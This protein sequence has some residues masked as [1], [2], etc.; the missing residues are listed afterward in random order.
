MTKWK[1]IGWDDAAG[2]PQVVVFP[3]TLQHSAMV[4]R[5]VVPK[6]AGFVTIAADYDGELYPPIL[7]GHSDSLNLKPRP[8]DEEAFDISQ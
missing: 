5:G 3:P 6:S 1:Y 2:V 4:P 7:S 8:E